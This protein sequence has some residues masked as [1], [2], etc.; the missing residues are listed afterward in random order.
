MPNATYTEPL[1]RSLPQITL[2]TTFKIMTHFIK[3]LKH[4]EIILYFIFFVLFGCEND[5]NDQLVE[6]IDGNIYNTAIIGNQI[7]LVENLKVT[8]YN[9]GDP[10]YYE[11]DSIE[12][13]SFGSQGAYC[14]YNN[15]ESYANIYGR[16]YNWH[17]VSDDRKIAPEGWHVPTDAEWTTLIDFLGG[18]S[19]A[20]GKLKESEFIH[21]QS[22][23]TGAT[24][25]S[26]FKALPGG[27]RMTR[28]FVYDIGRF[29]NISRYA[30]FWSCD[31]HHADGG[32]YSESW[33]RLL[34]YDSNNVIRFY[35]NASG[36]Y[37]RCIK[38]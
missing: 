25:E 33:I 37:V 29:E 11:P 31:I 14:N 15:D 34:S 8:H 10:I 23:N 13:C 7:W 17:A 27:S 26:G 20:G 6:D 38:D 22:P 4:L 3:T 1:L 28:G 9:N 2:R 24:N 35:N 32:T 21:W 12:W 5:N 18:D 19:I 16:I 30:Y 36:F